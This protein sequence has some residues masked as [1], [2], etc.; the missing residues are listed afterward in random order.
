MPSVLRKPSR[1]QTAAQPRSVG[2]SPSYTYTT[3]STQNVTCG[4]AP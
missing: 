2:S 4:E 3:S 1:E